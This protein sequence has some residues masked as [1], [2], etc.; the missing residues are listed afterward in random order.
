MRL[1]DRLALS[2][3]WWRRRARTSPLL[4]GFRLGL[5]SGLL[6][7]ADYL[8]GDWGINTRARDNRNFD[9]ALPLVSEVEYQGSGWHQR[10]DAPGDRAEMRRRTARLERPTMP[11]VG[12]VMSL[13]QNNPVG[14]SP[15][16]LTASRYSHPAL[17]QS[18]IESGR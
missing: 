18:R 2:F 16:R 9:S 8:D 7:L 10:L 1:A 11:L 3:P 17:G 15:A 6:P 4:T 14:R 13:G 5:S 12:Q